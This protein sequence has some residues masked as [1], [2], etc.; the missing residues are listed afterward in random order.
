MDFNGLA[1]SDLCMAALIGGLVVAVIVAAYVSN[2]VKYKPER[3]KTRKDKT[4]EV[5]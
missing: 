1:I 3:Y 2:L 4:D 5:E